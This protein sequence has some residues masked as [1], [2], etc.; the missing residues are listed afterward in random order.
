MLPVLVGLPFAG[1]FPVSGW[2]GALLLLLLAAGCGS[3]PGVAARAGVTLTVSAA[4]DLTPAFQELG[5]LF[6]GETGIGV[7]FNFGSSGQLAQQ[8]QRGA[9]VDLF[10]A[11]SV[12]YVEA[13]EREG[14]ILPE[15]KAVFAR[16]RLALWTRA[17]SPLGI[18]G[19]EE[20]ARP[21]VKRV[22]I[23]HPDHAPYG[24]AARQALQAAG[25][26]E[27]VQPKLVL[28]EN[29]RQALQYAETGNV[30]AA[31]VALSLSMRSQGRWSLVPQEL[32]APL[33]QA[34]V[35]LKSSKHPA[36]ARRLAEFI[37]GPR[38]RAVLAELGFTFPGEGSVP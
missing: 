24:V 18:G 3:Q 34:L 26:W 12:A 20:L 9:P 1:P 4:S 37:A 23:A 8:I 21:E 31:L 17:D 28:A 16:G 27:A 22:A 25:V 14:L 29:V 38:G 7:V 32:H 19:V 35:A 11:A 2:L 13:L 30:D 33:D 15:T 5:R 36:E 6:Q 10:A